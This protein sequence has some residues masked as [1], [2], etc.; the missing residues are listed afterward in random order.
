MNYAQTY[1]IG[2]YH[3]TRTATATTIA[4]PVKRVRQ[5]EKP[6]DANEV[7]KDKRKSVPTAMLPMVF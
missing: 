3:N 4:P 5:L 1:P 6:K 7:R 2:N